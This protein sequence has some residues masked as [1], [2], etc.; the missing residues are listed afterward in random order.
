VINVALQLNGVWRQQEEELEEHL[1]FQIVAQLNDYHL[2]DQSDDDD[3]DQDDSGDDDEEEDD[4]DDEDEDEDDD[5]DK[6]SLEEEQEEDLY[7]EYG[8]DEKEED[9]EQQER[10]CV[11]KEALSKKKTPLGLAAWDAEETGNLSQA[12]YFPF[13]LLS[14][15]G[16]HH[17]PALAKTAAE[18]EEEDATFNAVL[19]ADFSTAQSNRGKPP[20]TPTSL[21][22][23]FL[24]SPSSPPPPLPRGVD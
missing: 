18:E 23:V 21:F 15:T 5:D 22:F 4:E 14:L 19:N 13:P 7:D 24:S 16:G 12:G 10:A 1:L 17:S 8:D 9:K 20:S 3:D 2:M 6:S 11:A